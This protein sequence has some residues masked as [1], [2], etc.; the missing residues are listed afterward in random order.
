LILREAEAT[1]IVV[2]ILDGIAI[3]SADEEGLSEG[4]VAVLGDEGVGRMAL[5]ISAGDD[6]LGGDGPEEVAG[7]IVVVEGKVIVMER[8]LKDQQIVET[9]GVGAD[10]EIMLFE[11]TDMV[12]DTFTDLAIDGGSDAPGDGFEAGFDTGGVDY[13]SVSEVR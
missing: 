9:I 5:A 13:C 10:G 3:G 2:V 6:S 11:A 8:V 1:P 12:V 4:V 7:A